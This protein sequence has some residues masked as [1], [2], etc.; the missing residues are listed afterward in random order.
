MECMT[1][2]TDVIHIETAGFIDAIL[3]QN[4]GLGYYHHL[5]RHSHS[6]YG[7]DLCRYCLFVCPYGQ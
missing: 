2:S 1:P 5:R 6:D 4:V 7:L 3:C